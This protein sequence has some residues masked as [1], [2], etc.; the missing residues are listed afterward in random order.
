M[1]KLREEKETAAKTPTVPLSG[2]KSE[3]M[4]WKLSKWRRLFMT[5]IT[6]HGLLS[7]K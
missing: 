3:L 4:L 2:N 7:W 6:A 1:K 5:E